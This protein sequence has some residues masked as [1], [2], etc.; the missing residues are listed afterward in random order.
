MFLTKLGITGN[1]R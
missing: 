1:S